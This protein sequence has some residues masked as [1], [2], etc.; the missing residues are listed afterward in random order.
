MKLPLATGRGSQINPPNRFTRIAFEEDPEYFE[1]D[2]DAREARRTIRTEYYADDAKSVVSEN[3]S[4]DVPFRYSVNPYRGCS[5]GCS[6]CFAR[7]THEYLGLSAGLDFETKIFVKRR[8][9]NFSA[10]GW[11]A[12]AIGRRP[13]QSPA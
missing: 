3:D 10:T 2:E 1:H 11:P 8:A 5:H 9:R 6:Y 4:P 12:T 13:L 7:P